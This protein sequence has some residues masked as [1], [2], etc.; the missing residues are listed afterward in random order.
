M[1]ANTHAYPVLTPLKH[2]GQ[3]YAPGG[4]VEL[5]DEQAI[6]LLACGAVATAVPAPAGA[7]GPAPKAK[8]GKAQP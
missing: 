8:P 7:D 3:T 5:T 6:P 1:A 4:A 2:D